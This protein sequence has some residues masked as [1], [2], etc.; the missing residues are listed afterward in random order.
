MLNSTQVLRKPN[1]TLLP[2]STPRK[3]KRDDSLL[4]ETPQNKRQLSEMHTAVL[5]QDLP[6]RDIRLL[7]QKTTKGFEQLHY[8]NAQQQQ[9]IRALNLRVNELTNKKRKKIA[10]DP[11]ERFVNIETIVAVQEE[12]KRLQKQ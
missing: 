6:E 8:D 1:T 4:L 2:P 9:Q 10:I 12:Q 5:E 11:T 7:F 3:H